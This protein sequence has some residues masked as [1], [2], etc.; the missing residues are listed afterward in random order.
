M[1]IL[2]LVKVKVVVG[3]LPVLLFVLLFRVIVYN[4]SQL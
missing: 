4:S 2:I 1:I 3:S